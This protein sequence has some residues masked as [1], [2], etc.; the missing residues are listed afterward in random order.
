M[1]SP[2]AV[3]DTRTDEGQEYIAAMKLGGRYA[4]AGRDWVCDRVVKLLGA[5]VTESV[6]NHHNYA[7]RETHVDPETG[8]PV[9]LWV[10]R[11]GATPAGPGVKGFTGGSMGD[12][13]VIIEGVESPEAPYSY[14][15]TV[16]GAGRL[17]GR[18]QAK[19][20]IDENSMMKWV[21]DKGVELR[22]AGVDESP[23]CYKRIDDVLAAHGNSI[24]ILHTLEPIGVAMAGPDVRDPYKD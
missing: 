3:L 19:K 6:H 5:K 13:S 9:E 24:R 17:I 18:R 23:H 2:P 15:S 8:K 4:Y 21:H 12:R 1:D 16:H 11:K 10:V 20:T 7:W 22:G 14:Y